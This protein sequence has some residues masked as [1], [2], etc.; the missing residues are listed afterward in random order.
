MYRFY[1]GQAAPVSFEAQS[2]FA[3]LSKSIKL[4]KI[5]FYFQ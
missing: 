4:G 3:I 1:R 2:I 5:E